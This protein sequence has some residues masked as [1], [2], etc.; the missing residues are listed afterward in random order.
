MFIPS[1]DRHNREIDQPYRVKEALDTLGTLFGGATAFP[2]GRGVWRDD[3][4]GGVLLFDEPVVIQCYTTEHLLEERMPALRN[5]LQRMGREAH[6]GAVG[7]VIDG[8]YFEIGFPLEQPLR[9]KRK[10]RR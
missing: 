10:K 2:R 4:Q 8:D 1:M 6:Q 9:P 7:V 3:T 5:F